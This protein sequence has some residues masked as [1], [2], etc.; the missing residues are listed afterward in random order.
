MN[1]QEKEAYEGRKREMK[2]VSEAV[3]AMID[4]RLDGEKEMSV[5]K[6]LVKRHQ[7]MRDTLGGILWR[8][9]A[10]SCFIDALMG[11]PSTVHLGRALRELEYVS[12]IESQ[13]AYDGKLKA[14]CESFRPGLLD[15]AI[16]IQEA[17][18]SEKPEGAEVMP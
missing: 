18:A 9:N 7:R 4:G 1:E 16:K 13:V 11:D 14:E 2:E 5:L 17:S 8:R 12:V 6:K 15:K 3:E 10:L